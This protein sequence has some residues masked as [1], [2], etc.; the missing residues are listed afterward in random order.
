[1]EK[2]T[3]TMLMKNSYDMETLKNNIDHLDLISILNTQELTVDF[4]V[5]IILNEKYQVSSEEKNIDLLIVIN[6]QPHLCLKKLFKK[7][8]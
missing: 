2:I 4:C 5:D 1:M 8:S 6:K 7:I 3:N